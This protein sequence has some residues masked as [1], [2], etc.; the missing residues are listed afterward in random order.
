MDGPFTLH[1][2]TMHL[3]FW[4][5][6]SKTFTYPF[7]HRYHHISLEKLLKHG[8]LALSVVRN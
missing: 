7:H 1:K 5:L 2:G 4:C 8:F 3:T 6:I